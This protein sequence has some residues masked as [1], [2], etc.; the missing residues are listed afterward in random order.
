MTTN[1]DAISAEYKKA[2]QHPWRTHIEHFTLFE[3]AGDLAG[4]AVLDLACGEGYYTRSVKRH[5]AARAVGV[6]LSAGMIKLAKEEEA[7][8]PLGI[9]YQV[10]DA[11][12]VN[13]PE[14]FDLVVAGYLLN[15]ASTK[16]ELLQMCRAIS[17]SLKPGSRFLTVNNNPNHAPEH[18][19]LTQPY[20]FLKS[21]PGTLHEGAPVVWTFFLEEGPFAITNYHLSIATHES[22]FEAAGFRSVR[23]HQPRLS[24]AGAAE[25]GREYWTAFLEH[26][27]II[28]IECTK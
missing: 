18:F 12:D 15:Y 17:R 6:D 9:G 13:F 2:K 20:A 7:R 24:P 26:P 28:F 11:R 25:F 16:E 22:A 10:G 1:Y 19:P 4:K 3:L 14:T 5:G 23:W 27:P 8:S 21:T